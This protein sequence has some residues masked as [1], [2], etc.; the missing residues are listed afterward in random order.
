MC[1]SA[2]PDDQAVVCA[3]DGPHATHVARHPDRRSD[4]PLVWP[5]DRY[6]EPIA[7]PTS[8]IK[9]A[10]HRERKRRMDERTAGA[11]SVDDDAAPVGASHP[12]NAKAAAR[13]ALPRTGSK[14]RQA[15]DL[16]WRTPGGLT[17]EEVGLRFGWPHQSYSPC[18][19]TLEADGWLRPTGEMRR[20]QS[21]EMARVM[22]AVTEEERK[23]AQ[24]GVA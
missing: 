17:A 9:Q 4:P 18:I 7:R 14:R 21:G 6:V 20:T 23:Q 5:N 16:I 1:G 24:G 10:S 8:F 12:E 19:S 15:Y 11:R 2:H 3:V 22:E 13:R